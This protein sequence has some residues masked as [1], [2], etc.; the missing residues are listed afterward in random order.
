MSKSIV[1]FQ[2]VN[3][4]KDIIALR[5]KFKQLIKESKLCEDFKKGE[6]IPIK[7]HLG[8][9][10]NTG[11][12]NAQVIKTLV[13]KLKS[14]AAKPFI[15]DTN[16]LYHGQRVNAVDHMMLAHE[17][18]FGVNDIGA[19]VFISDGLFG[20][21]A[22]EVEINKKHFK[23]VSI[24]KP[25]L[26]FD[27]MISVA[28][29]TGHLLTGFAASIKNMGMGFASR[30]GKLRQHSNIKPLIREGNCILCR[31]CI[32]NCPVSAIIEKESRAFIKSESCI[33]CG[34]CIVACKYNA[35]AD[36]YGEDANILVEKMVE[37]AYGV[38]KYPKYK[39]FFN[40]AVRITK[41][42]DCM[43]KNEQNITN[44][45]GIFASTD[46]VACDKASS[47][48]VIKNS[49][50]DIFKKAYPQASL[51]THQLDYAEK[52]GLGNLD[53]ELVSVQ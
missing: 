44:D 26:Y 9:K 2:A 43:A 6:L 40:F 33:G 24:A 19:P 49:Q 41:N 28:H 32:E 10:G 18:G 45:V 38:L 16:V 34:E 47:D 1:Y 12:V 53:Y 22:Q 46:P 17:H 5:A 52:I 8:E 15:T 23:K 4:S 37:Y 35:V 48:M 42:C 13:D 3:D 30:A 11:H 39:V 14:K 31:R 27:K 7:M 51:Y 29:V 20:E 36:D 50:E 25:V 21:N